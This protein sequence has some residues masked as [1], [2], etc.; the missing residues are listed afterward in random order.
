MW[1]YYFTPT[2]IDESLRLLAEHQAR[3]RIIVGGT[4]IIL[5]LEQG[6]RPEVDI[7]IDIS[8]VHGLDKITTEGEL[9][10]LGPLVTHNHV[11]GSKLCVENAFPLALACWNVGAPQ[12][13]NRGTI[14][15]NLITGSPANDTIT[16][17]WAMDTWVTLQS[18]ERGQRTVSL[19]LFYRG[20]RQVDLA[21][22]EMLVGISFPALR[23]N[24]RGTF[25]KLGL[26]QAQAIAVVNVA[27]VLTFDDS[28][29]RQ[30]QHS[31]ITDARIT[32]GSVAPT[33]IRAEEAEAALIGQPLDAQTISRAAELATS[34]SRP[35]DDVRASAVYRKLMVEV[36]TR[37][38][39]TALQ[40]GAERNYW[41]GEPP[42]L[43]GKGSGRFPSLVGKTIV[44]RE[45]RGEPIQTVVNGQSVT[46]F[47][48]ND[49]TLLQMLRDELGLV[50]TKEGCAEGE[51]GAC[52]V[53]LDGVGVM[54]CLVP[55]PRAH[56]AEIITIEGLADWGRIDAK[57]LHP[58]QQAFID[59]GAV[60]C[61]Y[62]TPGL[63][64]SSAS[65]L[66]ENPHPTQEQVR[67][68]LSGNLC[69]CTGYYSILRAIDKVVQE[70][71]IP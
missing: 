14:A 47:G 19:P 38:A 44:H 39:L 49:K 20:V 52:T 18:A 25:L 42:M 69:R 11:V 27:A 57:G 48:A 63:L 31:R 67:Q 26:R 21:P 59:A 70:A 6:Q 9:I 56:G 36:F 33:I 34:A 45:G 12:I 50:G 54:S 65:L 2:S 13:R 62:C 71:S 46:V 29:D 43:W 64:M 55:A 60:Q 66:A 68:A 30:T 1:H 7:L 4:D 58:I 32:L 53:I 37:R 41:P 23:D 22:D 15:G 8:R 24:Q 61:G 3:S 5:E 35:I 51:C 40:Q 28:T 17:L 10:H 16:P